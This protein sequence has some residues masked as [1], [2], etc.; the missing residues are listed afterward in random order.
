MYLTFSIYFSCELL[1][2]RYSMIRMCTGKISQFSGLLS[3]SG[4][5][6][7]YDLVLSHYLGQKVV[8]V[9]AW[10]MLCHAGIQTA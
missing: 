2:H 6:L 10:R 1:Y 4:G 9:H 7:K 8:L 5:H 3:V